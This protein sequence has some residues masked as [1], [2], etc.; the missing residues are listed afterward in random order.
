MVNWCNG[1]AFGG[2]AAAFSVSGTT[3]TWSA[4]NAGYSLQTTDNVIAFYEK[5]R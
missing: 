4:S 1:K 3:I 5:A 2:G